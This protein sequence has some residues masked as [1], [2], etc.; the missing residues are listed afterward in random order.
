[1]HLALWIL[2]CVMEGLDLLPWGLF[3]PTKDFGTHDV[4]PPR[5]TGSVEF[6]YIRVMQC[7]VFI[8]Q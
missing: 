7:V 4:L 1:M 6:P 5:A 2:I 3:I 8:V